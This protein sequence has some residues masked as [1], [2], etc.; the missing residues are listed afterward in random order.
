MVSPGRELDRQIR[1]ALLECMQVMLRIGNEDSAREMGAVSRK[2][3]ERMA[4]HNYD[5]EDRKLETIGL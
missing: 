4:I 1:I 2:F 5:E 3:A